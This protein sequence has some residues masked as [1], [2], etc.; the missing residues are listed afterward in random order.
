MRARQICLNVRYAAS[1]IILNVWDLL[2][3]FY[4]VPKD[5]QPI[6]GVPD[7][8]EIPTTFLKQMLYPFKLIYSGKHKSDNTQASPTKNK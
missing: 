4:Y 1:G 8:K 5:K 3:G 2:F 7:Q 6:L